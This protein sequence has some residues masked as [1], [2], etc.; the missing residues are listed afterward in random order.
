MII[1]LKPIFFKTLSFLSAYWSKFPFSL[2]PAVSHFPTFPLSH[3]AWAVPEDSVVDINP[4]GC[5]YWNNESCLLRNRF[6]NASIGNV[7][8]LSAA[9]LMLSPGC[10]DKA[11]AFCKTNNEVWDQMLGFKKGTFDIIYKKH[12]SY[13][14]K[15]AACPAVAVSGIPGAARFWRLHLRLHI[16]FSYFLW[17]PVGCALMQRLRL[18]GNLHQN[19]VEPAACIYVTL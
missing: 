15:H 4:S 12:A 9:S 1:I 6:L 18:W 13:W 19:Q 17:I 8:G 2:L 5:L 3:L 10:T 16:I 14:G 7:T 11:K